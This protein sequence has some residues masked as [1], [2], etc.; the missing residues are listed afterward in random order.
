MS[1]VDPS[2]VRGP[3]DGARGAPL[4]SLWSRATDAFRR[5]RDGDARALDELVRTMTPVL[6]HIVRAYGLQP[7]HVDDV[8]QTTWLTFVRRQDDIADP[9]AVAGWL[10]TCAR[11]EAWR[12]AR[13]GRRTV[14]VEDAALESRSPRAEPAEHLAHVSDRDRRLWAAVGAL[15][16][17]CRRLLRIVAFEERPDY[18]G[19]AQDLA[20]PIG[21]I[22]PTRRRCLGKLRTELEGDGWRP[23]DF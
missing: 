10:T 7:A 3:G 17:R 14:A 12:T 6:W 18:A 2:P 11:R 20:M 13:A 1:D 22:G 9:K 5:S 4:D 21:S 23:G 16:E 8:V 15:D 19:I